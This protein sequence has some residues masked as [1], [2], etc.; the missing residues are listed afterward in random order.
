MR[1]L[2][3]TLIVVAVC[4]LFFV[5]ANVVL[6]QIAGSFGVADWVGDVDNGTIHAN[7]TTTLILII[8]AIGCTFLATRTG[9][10]EARKEDDGERS[11]SSTHQNERDSQLPLPVDRSFLRWFMIVVASMLFLFGGA[12]ALHTWQFRQTAIHAPGRVI[13]VVGT[14]D[15]Q[16]VFEFKDEA[17][18]QHTVTSQIN[19]KPATHQVGDVITVLYRRDAAKWAKIDSY[20][21]L[22]FGPT[23]IPL[24]IGAGFLLMAYLVGRKASQQEP[25]EQPTEQ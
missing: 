23:T 5:G 12:M 25:A 3:N 10:R 18:T 9:L 15:F 4:C 7:S 2:K 21:E 1:Y 19:S 20:W 8:F 14:D 11:R 16:V 13:K 24:M 22:W 17:G 6:L